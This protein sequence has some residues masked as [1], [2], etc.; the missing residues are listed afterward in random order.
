MLTNK[1]DI[2][3]WLKTYKIRNCTINED[4]SVDVDDMV[5]LREKNLTE[6]PVKFNIV[7][8]QFN[9][10]F[11]QLTST[12]FFPKEVNYFRCHDNQFKNLDNYPKVITGWASI[13][14][15]PNLENIIGLWN[16]DFRGS[17][18]WCDK[19]WKEE[20]EC[21]LSCINRLKEVEINAY[22]SSV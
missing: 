1:K 3:I 16:C 2:K 18:I 9:C 12:D 14:N 17:K 15:N 21:Y 20:I 6:I 11:N 8:G 19:K 13:E 7:N 5:Y 22:D 4:L 10:T